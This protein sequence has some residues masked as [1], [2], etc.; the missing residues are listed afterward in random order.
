MDHAP[1]A[2]RRFHVTDLSDFRVR[3]EGEE[4]RHAL[5]VLRLSVGDSVVLFDGAGA[6]AHGRIVTI[7]RDEFEAEVLDRRSR[8]VAQD[9]ILILAVS[10]PKGER[11][12]WMIEKCAEL[13]VSELIPLACERSQVRPGSGKLERWRR[14]VIAA[15]KQSQQITAMQIHEVRPLNDLTAHFATHALV[16]YGDT[17]ATGSPLVELLKESGILSSQPSERRRVLLLIGPEG[18]FTDH[19]RKALASSGGRAFRLAESVLRTETAAIAAAAIWATSMLVKSSS[20]L[21]RSSQE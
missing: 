11:A 20:G 6:E 14:K 3:V 7:G 18:G 12:D 1:V 2:I 21:T 19:E 10:P 17:T 16:L 4:A 13:G 5:R 8:P 9:C 15:A